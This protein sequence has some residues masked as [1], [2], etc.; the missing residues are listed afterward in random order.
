[1]KPLDADLKFGQLAV[2]MGVITAQELPK[3]MVDAR[4]ARERAARRP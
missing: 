3:L 4:L 1:V 2:K